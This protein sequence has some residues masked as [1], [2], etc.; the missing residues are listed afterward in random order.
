MIV[1]LSTFVANAA[2]GS[3]ILIASPNF[4]STFG[5]TPD[6]MMTNLIPASYLPAGKVAFESDGAGLTWWNLAWGGASY[7]GPNMGQ[8]TAGGGN[9]ADGNFNP[10]FPGPLPSANGQAI[11]FSGAAT[12]ASTNNAADYALTAGNATFTNNAG[13]SGTV[14][15][16]LMDFKIE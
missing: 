7:T 12:A 6:F 13:Q 8:T 16:E 5:V 9:D 3:R 4:A 1:D 2:T 15:V 10:P 11:L 14:P